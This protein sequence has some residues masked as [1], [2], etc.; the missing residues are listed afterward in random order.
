[1]QKLCERKKPLTDAKW[2]D[3]I[4]NRSGM[5]YHYNWHPIDQRF[6]RNYRNDFIL[7]DNTIIIFFKTY[8]VALRLG[9]SEF[10]GTVPMFPPTLLKK[11]IRIRYRCTITHKI[12]YGA[13]I[14]ETDLPLDSFQIPLEN[15]EF[16]SLLNL[17]RSED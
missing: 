10:I 11:T 9:Y 1:M 13:K 17:L 7:A 4:D 3:I 8:R 5:D 12:K 6:E 2:S 14:I 15:G 16:K